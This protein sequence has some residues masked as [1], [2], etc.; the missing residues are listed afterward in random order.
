MSRKGFF[1]FII[2]ISLPSFSFLWAQQVVQLPL[3]GIQKMEEYYKLSPEQ[4][5]IIQAELAKSGGVL[6]NEALENLRGRPEF[7]NVKPEDI[8]KAKDLLNQGV[9]TAPKLEQGEA[10]KSTAVKIAPGPASAKKAAINEEQGKSPFERARHIGKYQDISLDL[11]PF[12]YDFFREASVRVFA[13]R[14]DVPV[15]LKYVIGP[16]DEVK[17]LLW[18][19]VNAQ[20]NLT[21]DRDGKITVPQIGPLF[22]AGMTF[23]DM[24][25]HV[26]KQAEQIVGTNVDIS[27]GSLKTIPIFVLGDVRRPGSYTIGSFAT[28]TDA[29]LMAGGPT[30]IGSMR[31]IQLKRKE[32]TIATFDIYDLLL[33][34]DKS[35]DLT[36]QAGDIVFVPVTGPLVGIAGNVKRPAVYELKDIMTL[37]HLFDLAGGIIPTAT[38]QQ[39][40]IERII[41]TQKQIVVD[42][43]DRNLENSKNIVLQDV[44]LVKVF[45]IV[46]TNEATSITINGNVKKPGRYEF[47]P[48]MKIKDVL[49]SV[50]DFQAETYFDYALIKRKNM[51]NLEEEIIPFNPGKIFLENNSE[52][53]LALQARD[54]IFI[55]N[56][57]FFEDRP[58]AVITG[59]IRGDCNITDSMK[60]GAFQDSRPSERNCK[61]PITSSTR[62]RD[63]ILNAGGLTDTAFMEKGQLIRVDKNRTYKTVYF[64]VAKA[65]END[66]EENLLLQNEDRLVIHS[67]WEQV[68]K[69]TVHVDGDV[70]RPGEYQYTDG[71]KVKDLIF[72]GGNILESA[73]I[74]EAEISSLITEGRKISKVERITIN[75]RKAL[76]EDPENNILLRPND[77]LFVKRIPEWGQ[78]EIVQVDGEVR[79][80]GRYTIYK[81]EKLSS[82]LQRTGGYTENA[83]LR[84]AVFTRR[85]VQ[86]LQQQGIEDMAKRMER[87]LLSESSSQVSTALSIE[88]IKAKEIEIQQKKK[89]IET[90]KQLKASGRMTIHLGN[91]R[92]LKNSDYD[93]KL[94]EGDRLFI[95]PK[96]NV[97]NVMGSVMSQ[98]SYVYLDS[99]SANDYI[100]MAG[101]FTRYSDPSETFVLKVDGSARKLHRKWI[102]WND[103]SNRWQFTIFGEKVKE[104]EPGD[105]I[106]VPE[107]LARIA[108]LRE[109]RDIT[110]ILMNTAV[111][112]GVVI[113]LF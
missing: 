109:V 107:T 76:A 52:S 100:T 111:T 23:E 68:Y 27:M 39:I 48:G 19:R 43:D 35:K 5:S 21:V 41:K 50:D 79:F 91:L 70:F 34:G 77:R 38:T 92:L 106:V 72:K 60:S 31:K 78:Q 49:K 42:I 44:D 53:N 6:S 2:L 65:M 57:W 98:A 64:N 54:R 45:S 88:E 3:P 94:E 59:E 25:K 97:I 32:R 104:I 40:Q 61:L 108:W 102:S 58:Y 9:L 110:Q 112:A 86:E 26:I 20:Y 84:G 87:E 85:S 63:L 28:L 33:K 80:P 101:G 29:L 15:P 8:V 75:L 73:Y 46:D 13:E 4:R 1:L 71:M 90:F 10:T 11:K 18:G 89:F 96:N 103:S 36:L 93:I 69:K 22:V 47:K 37:Q 7:S 81:G 66:P 55:F 95:P 74:E 62:V 83:Y 82:L 105:T 30:E 51:P 12:G 113:K 99:L 67:I 14:K 56:K 17:L 16:G 24:S